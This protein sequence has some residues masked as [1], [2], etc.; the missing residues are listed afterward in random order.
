MA[1]IKRHDSIRGEFAYQ[2]YQQMEADPNIWLVMGDL[3][4]AMLDFCRRDFPERCINVG[5]AEQ[6]MLGIAVGLSEAGKRVF[7]YTISSFYLRAAETIALYL[8]GEGIPVRMVG[9]G[10]DDSYKHDGPSHHGRNAQNLINLLEI[11]SY[12]PQNKESVPDLLQKM[13]Q[14]DRPSFIGLQR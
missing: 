1:E 6:A 14:S 5:A 9:S 12:Y 7:T 8:A 11:K 4:Y 2:L 10:V 3:G 13:I